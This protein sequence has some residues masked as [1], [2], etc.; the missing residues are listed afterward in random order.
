M[1]TPRDR[2]KQ[3]TS[4]SPDYDIFVCDKIAAGIRDADAGRL[5][6][7]DEVFREFDDPNETQP[8]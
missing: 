8:N 5:A 3:R 2:E 7:H 4:D 1:D 6:S